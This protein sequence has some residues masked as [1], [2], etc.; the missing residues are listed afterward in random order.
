MKFLSR[1]FRSHPK[2]NLQQMIK[3]NLSY[4]LT[5]NTRKF[6]IQGL[7]D[8]SFRMCKDADEIKNSK[9][10]IKMILIIFSFSFRLCL[11]LNLSSLLSAKL[12]WG[13][14]FIWAAAAK[15]FENFWD[16]YQLILIFNEI[17]CDRV[18]IK[19]MSYEFANQCQCSTVLRLRIRIKINLI[20]LQRFVGSMQIQT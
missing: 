7:W 9:R 10:R 17:S 15:K 16:R 19:Q 8:G 11:W 6:Q 18:W 4:F 2:L 3:T 20:Q 12:I 1:S 13:F 5:Q 14:L